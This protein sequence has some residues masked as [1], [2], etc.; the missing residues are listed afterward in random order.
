M[1]ND[2]A[3]NWSIDRVSNRDPFRLERQCN[4]TVSYDGLTI[5]KGTLVSIATFPLHYSEE[6]YDEPEKFDPDR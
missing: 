3:Q 4:K 1:K 6:Y 5:K 2:F